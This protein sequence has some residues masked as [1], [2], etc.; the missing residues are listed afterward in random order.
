MVALVTGYVRLSHPRSH[1]QYLEHGR[2]LLGLGLPTVVFYDGPEAELDAPAS[3]TVCPASLDRCWLY[4]ATRAAQTPSPGHDKD[5]VNYMVVQHQKTAWLAA[6]ATLTGA[7]F[8]VWVDFGILHLP[9]FVEHDI[10]PFFDRVK[11]APPDRVTLPGI[12]PLTTTT[13]IDNS[14]VAWHLAGGVVI[15][16]GSLAAWFHGAT[17][18][19]ARRHLDATGRTTWE[20]NTWAALAQQFPERFNIYAADHNETLFTGLRT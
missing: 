5:S 3:A 9:A 10:R 16:P 6:A 19:E 2:R 18:R 1:A 14:R 17:E 13:P 8:L 7:A 4:E 12:W 20:V 11:H 15:C